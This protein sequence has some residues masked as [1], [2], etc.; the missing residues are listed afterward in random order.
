MSN[1]ITHVLAPQYW[2][3]DCELVA[4]ADHRQLRSSDTVTFVITRT[5]IRLGDRAFPVAGLRL[6]KSFPSN[7]RQSDLT[8]QQFR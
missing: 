6:W 7:L 1:A 3:E 4:A 5:Y 2:D 8:L